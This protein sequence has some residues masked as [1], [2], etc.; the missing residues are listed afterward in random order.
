MKTLIIPD[1]HLR[2]RLAQKVIK[3][4]PHD[5]VI[6][7]GDAFDDFGDTPERNAEMA[8]WLTD[9]MRQ[10]NHITLMG[11]HDVAYAYYG[12]NSYC[13]GYSH[14]KRE[15]I[16]Q[17]LPV[18]EYRDRAK[19]YHY[20]HGFLFSHAGFKYQLYK[21][22][23]QYITKNNSPEDVLKVLEIK[24]QNLR[25]DLEIDRAN[26]LTEVGWARNGSQPH[27]GLTWCCF[28]EFSPIPNVSQIF[29]HTPLK[30]PCFVAPIKNGKQDWG[31]LE[32]AQPE[33]YKGINYNFD[34]H[35][36]YFGSITDGKVDYH[37]TLDFL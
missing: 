3:N 4:F 18:G 13:S 24:S 9:F 19:F 12:R 32:E 16:L 28:K 14:L 5:Q 8:E 10:P 33:K 37:L 7:L 6:F 36:K 31:F 29:G 30:R 27:G 17:K 15:A 35:F 25:A 26:P 23:R 21:E 34:T 11:N 1:L 20:E 2:W 22:L